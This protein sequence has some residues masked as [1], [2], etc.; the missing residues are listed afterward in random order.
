MKRLVTVLVSFCI[1]SLCGC[2]PSRKNDNLIQLKG[3]DTMVNLGQA[4]AEDYMN[5]HSTEF[6]AVTGGGS[7]TGIASLIS[8]SCQIAM[9]SRPVKEKEIKLAKEHGREPVEF[10]AAL[11]GIA[12]I[13]NVANPVKQVTLAQLADI[14][15]GRI[16][17]WKELG[18]NDQPIV[19]LSREV[20][21]GTHM[22]FKEHVICRNDKKCKDEFAP[23]A[24][25]LPSS[26]AIVDEVM[27]NA[28]GIGYLGLGYVT[29]KVRLL[30]VAKVDGQPYVTPTTETIQSGTYPIS[31]PLYLY[32]NGVP[33]GL[34]K[35]F[36][37]YVLS[38]EGR[39]VTVATDFIPCKQ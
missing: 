18:G 9:S 27:G 8:G 28:G 23:S 19:L 21:S 30:D 1:V 22:Y 39:T 38:Q 37:E 14:F 32:S 17:N 6:I 24:L 25:M 2:A 7:G 3:S 5:K 12:V 36:I 29:E 26:Q 13:V 20:N 31:R 10:V 33:Q 16:K 11:D 4:W 34:V 35:R 15:T